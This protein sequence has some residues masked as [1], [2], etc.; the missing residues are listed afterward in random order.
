MA[1]FDFHYDAGHGWLKVHI[2]DAAD[3]GPY[4]EDFSAYSYRN[5]EHLYLEED[6]DA[7]RFIQAWEKFKRKFDVR[8]V[9]DGYNSPIRSYEHIIPARQFDDEIP[10]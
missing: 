4:A 10:F 8:H 2:Y 9:D 3:V 5:G 1:K 7:G 6:V